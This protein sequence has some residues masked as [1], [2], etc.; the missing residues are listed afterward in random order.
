MSCYLTY[1]FLK[2]GNGAQISLNIWGVDFGPST[3]GIKLHNVGIRW[4]R[5]RRYK[6]P[7]GRPGCNARGD[8]VMKN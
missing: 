4:F 8:R 5:R 1:F 3:I 7:T 2:R 6:Y